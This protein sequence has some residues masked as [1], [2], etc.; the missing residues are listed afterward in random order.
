MSADDTTTMSMYAMSVCGVDAGV[1]D[2]LAA[3]LAAGAMGPAL[4]ASSATLALTGSVLLLGRLF[5]ERTM[6]AVLFLLVGILSAAGASVVVRGAGKS[7][8]DAG[9]ALF[10][11]SEGESRCAFDLIVVLLA[12]L[13]MASLATRLIG[14]AFFFAGAL[15]AGY[16]AWLAF[17]AL[18]PIVAQNLAPAGATQIEVRRARRSA[19]Q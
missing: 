11:M 10:G 5:G 12:A 13:T 14:L 8:T 19:P 18:V 17:G 1:S 6:A 9:A 16:A 15:G 7:V 3:A 4:F 2:F